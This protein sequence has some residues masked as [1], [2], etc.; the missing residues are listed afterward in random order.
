ML[1][2][3]GGDPGDEKQNL[4]HFKEDGLFCRKG[5]IGNI[6]VM[7]IGRAIRDGIGNE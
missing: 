1:Y 7:G 3:I 2:E 6:P 5:T 4:H